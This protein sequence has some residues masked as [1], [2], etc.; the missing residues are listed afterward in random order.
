MFLCRH[1]IQA[2]TPHGCEYSQYQI[3]RSFPAIFFTNPDIFT[4]PTRHK[5]AAN[6]TKSQSRRPH[7]LQRP[8]PIRS[9]ILILISHPQK[10]FLPTTTPHPHHPLKSHLPP[11]N[12]PTPLQPPTKSPFQQTLSLHQTPLSKKCQNVNLLPQPPT[13][14]TPTAT[15]AS[16][17]M[18]TVM[19]TDER[20]RRLR[21]GMGGRV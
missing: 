13:P 2:I 18:V 3:A 12:L 4:P 8:K 16:S 20:R 1:S 6:L 10:I 19:S 21:M 9:P 7:Q 5:R 14:T 17:T 11:P 15:A